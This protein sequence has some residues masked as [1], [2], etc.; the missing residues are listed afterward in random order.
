MG[1]TTTQAGCRI[2]PFGAAQDFVRAVA[3]RAGFW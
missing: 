2:L 1:T 3:G